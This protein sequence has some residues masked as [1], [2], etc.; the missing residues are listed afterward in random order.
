MIFLYKNIPYSIINHCAVKRDLRATKNHDR[1]RYRRDVVEIISLTN[2]I[3]VLTT[4]MKIVAILAVAITP[5]VYYLFISNILFDLSF[6]SGSSIYNIV[7]SPLDNAWDSNVYF[8]HL[9]LFIL[10]FDPK[11]ENGTQ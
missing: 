4:A 8:I 11:K 1:S 3:A 10:A 6:R 5:K 9:L 7:S 2:A